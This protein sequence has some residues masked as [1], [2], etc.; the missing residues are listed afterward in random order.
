[1]EQKEYLSEFELAKLWQVSRTF[2]WR[3][4]RDGRGP[5]HIR[6]GWRILYRVAEVDRWVEENTHQKNKETRQLRRRPV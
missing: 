5:R 6:I 2:L 4:R 1:M 3:L